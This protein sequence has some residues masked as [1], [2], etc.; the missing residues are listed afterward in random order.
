MSPSTHLPK[1]YVDSAER[2]KT[3]FNDKVWGSPSVQFLN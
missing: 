2:F 3:Y 1:T